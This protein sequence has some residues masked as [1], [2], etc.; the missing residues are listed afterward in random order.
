MASR[1]NPYLSFT[2]NAREAMTFYQG[3]FGGTLNTNTFKDFGA[4]QGP[5]DEDLIMHSQLECA[6][7]M[8]LMAADTPA[9]REHKPGNTMSISLSGEDDA[10]LSSY[11]EKLAEGGAVEQPLVAA[12]WGDKFGSLTDKYGVAWLVNIAGSA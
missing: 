1:L 5:A 10:E 7:G 11:F 8:V 2:D 4:A 12:P 3:V 6:N 9:Y